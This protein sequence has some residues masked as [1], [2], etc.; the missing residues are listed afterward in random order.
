MLATQ[1]SVIYRQYFTGYF[2]VYIPIA[3]SNIIRDSI[4][5]KRVKKEDA[6]FSV[7]LYILTL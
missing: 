4:Q 3:V 1:M 6:A 5:L 7:L 2:T